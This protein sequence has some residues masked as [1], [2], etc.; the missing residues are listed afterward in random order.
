MNIPI[1][2]C[3]YCFNYQIYLLKNNGREKI[4]I[5][6]ISDK[7]NDNANNKRQTKTQKKVALYLGVYNTTTV[8]KN[9]VHR[10]IKIHEFYKVKI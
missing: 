3:L 8:V 2:S 7:N 10:H 9:K 5:I 1:V 6:I 4:M